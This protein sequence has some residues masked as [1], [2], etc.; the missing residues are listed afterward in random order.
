MGLGLIQGGSSVGNLKYTVVHNVD[1][2][3]WGWAHM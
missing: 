3:P 2:E 1:E